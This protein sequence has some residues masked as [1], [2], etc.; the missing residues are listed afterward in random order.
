MIPELLKIGP[1]T[2][3]SFGVM[4]MLA[5]LIPTMLMRKEFMRKEMDPELASGI[6]IAAMVGGFLGARI[7][8][9]LERWDRFLANPTDYIFT[10]AGLVWYGGFIGGFISVIWYVKR[11][12]ISPVLISDL[13]AP[14][15]AL[16]QFF[17][18]AGCFLAA[19][20]DYGP[21]TDVP[22]AM[23]FPHGI[24][25]TNEMVHPTPI[26][27]MFFLSISFLILWKNRKKE[28]AP[29]FQFGLYLI[30]VGVGRIITEFYRTTP[31]VA[32]GLTMAQWISIGLITIGTII[33]IRGQRRK[34]AEGT[35]DG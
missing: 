35:S 18:R 7:Y 10:G 21:P 5:F 25:P 31:I 13:Y 8:F 3:N 23:S 27:D 16:G 22:W 30:L 33:I 14:M 15:L 9:I 2:I 19:D 20:G 11:K 12:N 24:V 1:I 6:A 28:L 26:Y 32:L 17:G 4:A 34:T 29:G